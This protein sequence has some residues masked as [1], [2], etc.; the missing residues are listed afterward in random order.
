MEEEPVSKTGAGHTVASSSLAASALNEQS[1]G[2]AAT[3]PGLHP[4][5]GGSSPSGTT[6]PVHIRAGTLIGSVRKLEKRRSSELRDRLWVQLP[7]VPLKRKVAGCGSPGRFAKPCDSRVRWVRLPCLP[8]TRLD[9]ET[10][11][12]P[13]FERGVPGS[14][15]GRATKVISAWCL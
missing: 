11:I 2:P 1:R 5:N 8:L 14:I 15:P 7:P 3:T 12:I 9:G 4:G 6:A 10:E 13:R